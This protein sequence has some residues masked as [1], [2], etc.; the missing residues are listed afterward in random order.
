MEILKEGEL[1]NKFIGKLIGC[2]NCNGY[3]RLTD[4]DKNLIHTRTTPAY[5]SIDWVGKC[6]KQEMY[7]IK[8][9]TKNCGQDIDFMV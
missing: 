5:T 8:C 3:F 4:E 2:G 1:T 7:Y 6:K 9:P